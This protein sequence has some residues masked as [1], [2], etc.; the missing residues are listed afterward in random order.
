LPKRLSLPAATVPASMPTAIETT[1]A[2]V[3]LVTT[4]GA[5]PVTPEMPPLPPPVTV[6]HCQLLPF[7]CSTCPVVHPLE[8]TEMARVVPSMLMPGPAV[9]PADDVSFPL[10]SMTGVPFTD[11][12]VASTVPPFTLRAE[13]AYATEPTRCLGV[14][15][16]NWVS[17]AACTATSSHTV[18]ESNTGAGKAVARPR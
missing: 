10:A 6:A 18:L 7:H 8:F 16:R 4:T 17:P 3:P 9:Y 5:V 12:L 14:M 13:M 2:V 11:T 15:V 1:G